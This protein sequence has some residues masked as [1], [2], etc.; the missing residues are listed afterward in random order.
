MRWCDS[1]GV[2]YVL[3][4]ARNPVLE[5][6]AADWVAQAERQFEKTGLPQRIFGSFA[7]EAGAGTG[8]DE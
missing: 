3:G 6:L 7:Y 4:L 2:G 5:R 8:R 1:N